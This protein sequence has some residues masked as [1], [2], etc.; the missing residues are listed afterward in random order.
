MWILLCN[1]RL[2]IH[3]KSSDEQIGRTLAFGLIG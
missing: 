3:V 2:Y 1:Y